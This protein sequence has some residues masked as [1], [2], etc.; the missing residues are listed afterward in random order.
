[1][2][3][4]M[5]GF[6]VF[7]L[8]MVILQAEFHV[9]TLPALS[10]SKVF[11]NPDFFDAQTDRNSSDRN[12][13][14]AAFEKERKIFDSDIISAK[15]EDE[16]HEDRAESDVPPIYD[17]TFVDEEDEEEEEDDIHTDEN[18]V[19]VSASGKHHHRHKARH[20][21][22]VMAPE[23]HM[24]GLQHTGGLEHSTEEDNRAGLEEHSRDLDDDDA[25]DSK[26]NSVSRDSVVDMKVTLKNENGEATEVQSSSF[27]AI[28]SP[29]ESTEEEVERAVSFFERD[30]R[31]L[32]CFHS[33]DD[34]G[35]YTMKELEELLPIKMGQVVSAGG[36][37]DQFSFN[38]SSSNAHKELCIC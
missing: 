14:E 16:D 28:G 9:G 15:E 25:P 3:M 7:A 26:Q 6:T 30:D 36:E 22:H 12:S 32:A 10:F 35:I 21:K 13:S 37:G 5:T 27:V 1:M 11:R 2:P 29:H 23:G 38:S 19:Q 24:G 18:I 20:S 8:L 33:F 4:F 34:C 31:Q 17:D